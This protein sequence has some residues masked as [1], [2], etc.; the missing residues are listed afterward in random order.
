MATHHP[1]GCIRRCSRAAPGRTE[2]QSKICRSY[3]VMIGCGG[4]H[5]SEI[6]YRIPGRFVQAGPLTG[7]CSHSDGEDPCIIYELLDLPRQRLALDCLG[8]PPRPPR[9]HRSAGRK[10]FRKPPRSLIIP[11]RSNW[12]AAVIAIGGDITCRAGTGSAG[13]VTLGRAA[14]RSGRATSTRSGRVVSITAASRSAKF[15]F[16]PKSYLSQSAGCQRSRPVGLMRPGRRPAR[17][18]SRGR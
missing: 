4:R 12:C 13:T 9:P 14:G 8:W 2:P 11:M 1:T 7:S 10:G 6:R 15:G 5:G 3:G 17:R 18:G 16:A